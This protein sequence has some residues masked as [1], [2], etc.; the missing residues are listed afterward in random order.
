MQGRRLAPIAGIVAS[1]AP[2]GLVVAPYFVVDSLAVGTYYDVTVL[3]PWLVALFGVV[4]VI[5]L[6]AGVQDRTAPATVA[7]ASLVF[8]TVM[9]LIAAIW[10]LSVPEGLV[11]QLGT[12]EAL[13]YHRWALLVVSSLVPA[14]AAWYAAETL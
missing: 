12:V 11:E 2:V 10:A 14:S 1:L 8:G 9:V 5:V 3:G 6:L 7:G 4:T 13:T